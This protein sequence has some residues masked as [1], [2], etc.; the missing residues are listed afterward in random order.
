VEK[1]QLD[2]WEVRWEADGE[3]KV[4]NISPFAATET[5]AETNEKRGAV[6]R[7]SISLERTFFLDR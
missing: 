7:E 6:G 2:F 1:K 3:R 5:A 4:A